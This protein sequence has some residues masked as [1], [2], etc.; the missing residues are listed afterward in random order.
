MTVKSSHVKKRTLVVPR[1]LL[2]HALSLASQKTAPLKP[3]V[4]GGPKKWGITPK[5]Q[6]V[7]NRWFVVREGTRWIVYDFE[8]GKQ[9]EPKGYRVEANAID[10]AERHRD[11]STAYA[12]SP[13]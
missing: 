13:F 5:G 9:G 7:V 12:R 2:L 8:E 10:F 11:L 6:I 3:P 1:S 4:L